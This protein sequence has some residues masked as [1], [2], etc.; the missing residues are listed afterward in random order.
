MRPHFTGIAGCSRMGWPGKRGGGRM[1]IISGSEKGRRLRAVRGRSVRPT[2]GRARTTLFD[3]L[4]A[5]IPNCRFLDLYAGVGS[6]GLEALSRGAAS[7]TFVEQSQKACLMLRE[8][9]QSLGMKDRAEVICKRA[10][11]GLKLL[12]LRGEEFELVF[13]DPPY[14]AQQEALAVLR[15]LGESSLLGE[16]AVVVLQHSSRDDSPAQTASLVLAD[17]RRVGDTCFCFFEP[18]GAVTGA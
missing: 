14:K 5:R 4:A 9:I 18:L 2:S 15:Y 8:N 6:V 16:D 11:P 13:L 10:G 1:R 17:S 7:A 12:S 3:M